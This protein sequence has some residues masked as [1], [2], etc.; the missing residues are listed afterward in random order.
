[1][2]QY[3]ISFNRRGFKAREVDGSKMSQD[4]EGFDRMSCIHLVTAA[5]T[6]VTPH[7]IVDL[8]APQVGRNAST[9]KLLLY[10]I[11]ELVD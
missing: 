1:M 6:S 11:N 7:T 10:R 4:D 2:L 9:S 5:V 8:G 3:A